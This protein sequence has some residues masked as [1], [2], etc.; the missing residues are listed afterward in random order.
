MRALARSIVSLIDSV[1]ERVDAQ[2]VLLLQQ[3]EANVIDD[4]GRG[5]TEAMGDMGANVVV[6]ADIEDD[7][8]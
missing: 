6:D 1:S 2:T 4:Y 5:Y 7:D 3:A 8:C